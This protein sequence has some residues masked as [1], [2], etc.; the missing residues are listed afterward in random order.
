MDVFV[1]FLWS[2]W[3]ALKKQKGFKAE[4]LGGGQSLGVGLARITDADPRAALGAARKLGEGGYF[5]TAVP[6][7]V[8]RKG[9]DAIF[10]L[11]GYITDSRTKKTVLLGQL[12]DYLQGEDE[13]L[14]QQP[15]IEAPDLDPES[16]GKTSRKKKGEKEAAGVSA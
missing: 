9:A 3:E 10:F 11:S 7:M 15:K 2:V 8:G 5:F 14:Q 12:A 13:R 1:V 4:V 6:G 16:A